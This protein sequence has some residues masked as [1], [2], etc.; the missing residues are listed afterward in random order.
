MTTKA[1]TKP[2]HGTPP[3]PPLAEMGKIETEGQR[4][5]KD[6]HSRLEAIE[7]MLGDVMRMLVYHAEYA[8]W[9]EGRDRFAG[10]KPND[11]L[12]ELR[13]QCDDM[14]KAIANGFTTNDRPDPDGAG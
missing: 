7:L 6:F 14:R 11:R 13:R 2:P 1:A 12:R 10:P 3:P 9:S 8:L 4:T 5:T